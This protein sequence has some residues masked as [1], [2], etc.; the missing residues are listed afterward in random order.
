M[1]KKYCNANKEFIGH[2]NDVISKFNVKVV[3][4]I[5]VCVDS[6]KQPL[7]VLN[8]DYNVYEWNE[9]VMKLNFEYDDGYVGQRLFGFIWYSD[10]SWSDRMEYDGA[11]WWGY[12]KC[13]NFNLI[14]EEAK[15]E[16][17]EC[18]SSIALKNYYMDMEY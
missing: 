4:A 9:F 14:L 1:S 17:H 11:E 10:G 5:I 18:S 6:D 2:I 12:K 15:K 3:S 8:E 13:P 16:N 7:I